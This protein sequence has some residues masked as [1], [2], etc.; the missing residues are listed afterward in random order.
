MV[1]VGAAVDVLGAVV[2]VGTLVVFAGDVVVVEVVF[3]VLV[4]LTTHFNLLPT[5]LHTKR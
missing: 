4:F 2:V 3:A 5:F 1:A